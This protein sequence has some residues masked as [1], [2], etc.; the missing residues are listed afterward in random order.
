IKA[1]FMDQF[2][3]SL[4]DGSVK[5]IIDSVYPIEKTEEAQQHMLEN[6]NIGKI[7]LTVRN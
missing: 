5:T 7:I 3:S 1:Q 6:K 4:V 2:W